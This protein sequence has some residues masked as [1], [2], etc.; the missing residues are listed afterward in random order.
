MVR[1]VGGLCGADD[2]MAV[3]SPQ[4]KQ[5]LTVSEGE[6]GWGGKVIY[7]ARPLSRRVKGKAGKKLARTGGAV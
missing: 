3:V 5:A 1:A 4:N 6:G 2:L 7:R